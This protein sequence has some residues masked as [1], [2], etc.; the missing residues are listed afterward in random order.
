MSAILETHGLWSTLI[1]LPLD[2]GVEEAPRLPILPAS[3]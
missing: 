2:G 3:K 1:D